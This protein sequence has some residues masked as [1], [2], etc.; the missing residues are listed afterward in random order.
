MTS[1]EDSEII[2]WNRV[3]YLVLGIPYLFLGFVSI[4]SPINILLG[5]FFIALAIWSFYGA[6]ERGKKK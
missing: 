1:I 4:Y 5:W 3:R 2:F 6:F